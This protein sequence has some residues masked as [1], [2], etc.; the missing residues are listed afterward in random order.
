MEQDKIL[1]DLMQV[2]ENAK[3]NK[4]PKL[5]YELLDVIKIA[6][7][8]KLTLSRELNMYLNWTIETGNKPDYLDNGTDFRHKEHMYGISKLSDALEN[9]T[10]PVI[11]ADARAILDICNKNDCSYF[12]FIE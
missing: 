8:H 9:E 10:N 12:R 11:L 1:K 5:E 2:L 3:E 6:D 7:F 4:E